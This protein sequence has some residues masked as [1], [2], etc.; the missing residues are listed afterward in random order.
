MTPVKFENIQ[1]LRG[2]AVLLVVFCHLQA[3]EQKYS[4]GA[5]FLPD[6]LDYA[7]ASVDLFFV[8]SGFVIATVTRGQFQSLSKAGH[9]IFQRVTRIYPPY[10][11]YSTLVLIIWLYKPE[12]VNAGQGHQ[13][14]LLA[15]FLIIPQDLLP[16]VMVGWTLIHEMY[17]YIVITVMMPI[18]PERIFP[19]LLVLWTL[20]VIS[21]FL[22]FITNCDGNYSATVRV[23]FHPLTLDFIGGAA[24]ALLLNS[25]ILNNDRVIIAIVISIFLCSVIWFNINQS[26]LKI[27]GLLRVLLFGIPSLL[28][29]YAAA[30]SEINGTAY[31]PKSMIKIGDASYSIYLS[32]VLVLSALGRIWAKMATTGATA[33]V[34]MLVVMLLATISVGLLSYRWIEIPILNSIRRWRTR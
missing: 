21:G 30:R 20:I 14:N 19:V 16:L 28:V 31:F 24:A 3:I 4:P 2:V 32:H 18:I 22:Y 26:V 23:I 29:V 9:F 12:M 6:W 17:F 34:I 11:F 33:H 13:I 7:I 25:R 27:E 10:W 5:T 8:I 15:S 1:A